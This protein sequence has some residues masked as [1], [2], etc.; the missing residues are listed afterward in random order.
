MFKLG[1]N[2]PFGYLKQKLS[3]K[4]GPVVTLPI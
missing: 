3:P 2:D 4:Q 1:L